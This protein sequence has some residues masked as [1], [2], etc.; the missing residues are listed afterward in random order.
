MADLNDYDAVV[1]AVE[2]LVDDW[3]KVMQDVA[4]KLAEIKEE[5]DKM[6]ALKKQRD[7][8]AKDAEKAS[9]ELSDK[10]FGLKVSPKADPQPFDGLPDAIKKMIAKGG[11]PL[12]GTGVTVAP[13]NWQIDPP[14]KFKVKGAGLKLEIKF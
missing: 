6:E 10:I 12:G 5:M 14:P 7:A 2:T 8:A 3:K 11:V 13:S 9:K 1:D 4:K